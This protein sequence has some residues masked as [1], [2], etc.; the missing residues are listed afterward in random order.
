MVAVK[1]HLIQHVLTF[2]IVVNVIIHH[3]H[4]M[5]QANTVMQA[6]V[7]IVRMVP[8]KVNSAVIMVPMVTAQ[9]YMV[10]MMYLIVV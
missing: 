9:V 3:I 2:Q 6:G 7:R 1:V 10:V 4:V 5:A 8:M